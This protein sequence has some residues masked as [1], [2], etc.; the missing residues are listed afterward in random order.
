MP[1]RETKFAVNARPEEL[2][3]FIRD[4]ES[5]CTCIP[6]VEKIDLLDDRTAD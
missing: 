2:W 1:R 6:G 4:F 3:T 5:L